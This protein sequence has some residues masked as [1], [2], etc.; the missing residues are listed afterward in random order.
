M[1]RNCILI[2]TP[3]P[4]DFFDA[5]KMNAIPIG[6]IFFE[7]TGLEQ[8]EPWRFGLNSVEN[9]KRR[10]PLWVKVPGGIHFLI[11]GRAYDVALCT[12]KPSEVGFNDK[13]GWHGEGWNVSGEP[14]LIS[15]SPSIHFPGHYHGFLTN[16][17]LT[18]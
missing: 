10:K 15:C 17:V 7:E 12:K 5:A 14:P 9:L 16:G 2:P 13:A 4:Q 18:D 6:A 3:A 8:R 1:P 11:D